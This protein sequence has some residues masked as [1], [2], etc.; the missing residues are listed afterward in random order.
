VR[1]VGYF[2]KKS[3]TMQGNRNVKCGKNRFDNIAI[4][5]DFCALR[6]FSD[7]FQTLRYIAYRYMYL[8]VPYVFATKIQMFSA[9]VSREKSA[10]DGE[11]IKYNTGNGTLF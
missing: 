5:L 6:I 3:I 7:L 4:G 8:Y 11:D 2:K 1:L 9:A 10:R